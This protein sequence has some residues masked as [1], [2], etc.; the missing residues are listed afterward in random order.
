MK[1]ITST[2][3]VCRECGKK[4]KLTA[5]DAI[6]RW[7]FNGGCPGFS[8]TVKCSH[9]NEMSIIK[10]TPAAKKLLANR[11]NSVTIPNNYK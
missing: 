9:C 10:Q 8:V 11:I 2:T 5:D 6:I 1:K 3:I 4:I 7:K